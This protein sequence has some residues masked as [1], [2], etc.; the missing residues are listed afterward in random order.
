MLHYSLD[1]AAQLSALYSG[2]SSHFLHRS[3]LW[4][5]P[6]Y[7]DW[8]FS[9]LSSKKIWLL[10]NCFIKWSLF[11]YE[12]LSMTKFFFYVRNISCIFALKTKIKYFETTLY[13]SKRQI[14][15]SVIW[16]IFPI[17]MHLGG[18]H[19]N[20]ASVNKQVDELVCQPLKRAASTITP[21][22]SSLQDRTAPIVS[23]FENCFLSTTE[24][25]DNFQAIL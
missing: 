25:T 21:N 17:P 5:I 3:V 24:T 16:I 12:I 7:C 19:K 2:P 13:F 22:S 14:D 4:G 8:S 6:K 23:L 1:I 15:L 18:A 11:N 9:L 20:T 10:G